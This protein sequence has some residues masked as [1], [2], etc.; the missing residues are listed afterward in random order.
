[1]KTFN[2]LNI[3]KFYSF[4]I[5]I[6]VGC[7]KMNCLASDKKEDFHPVDFNQIPEILNMISNKILENYK[8]IKT[9]QGKDD[10]VKEYF[11]EG[12]KAE[13]KFKTNTKGQGE[14]PKS[15]SERGHWTRDFAVD[16][17]NDLLYAKTSSKKPMEYLDLE[18]GKKF[19]ATVF[20]N[21]SISIM[22]PESYVYTRDDTMRK[23]IVMSRTALKE[24]RDKCSTCKKPPV[25]DPRQQLEQSLSII[26][27]SF[28]LIIKKTRELGEN[29]TD[30]FIREVEECLSDDAIEYRVSESF[31]ITNEPNDPNRIL[32][33]SIFSSAKGF[34]MISKE[35]TLRTS[36]GDKLIQ[37]CTWDFNKING[38][39]VL[40]RTTIQ[41]YS[42]NTGNPTFEETNVY[43]DI[44]IN[45]PISNEIFNYNN[46]GL[47]DG[48]K[49][50]DNIEKKEYKYKDKKLVFVKDI[51]EPAK[52]NK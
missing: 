11:F 49:F 6:L 51:N 22:T 39:Y 32:I 47:K 48:D 25:F 14:I 30:G 34:N 10:V 18:N 15:L 52:P 8:Q 29:K 44:K 37:K 26:Q 21:N 43:S 5:L 1:M 33:S 38:I 46:L 12:V 50:I 40:N 27:K 2:I 24:L 16:I 17:K 23:G 45:Q 31:K 35:T 20:P 28:P 13:Q 4:I 9:W 19:D 7:I 42:F 3:I 41:N 36:D